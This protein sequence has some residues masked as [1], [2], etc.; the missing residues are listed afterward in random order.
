VM[1]RSRGVKENIIS[2]REWFIISAYKLN[3]TL[4]V[5]L[6]VLY[7]EHYITEDEIVLNNIAFITLTFAQLFHVFNISSLH[8]R[9]TINEIT[10][11]KLV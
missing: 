9:L 8:S 6:A 3:L 7:T 4:S 11:N 1:Q 2:S 10:T 5:M